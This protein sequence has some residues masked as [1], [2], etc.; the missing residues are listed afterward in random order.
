MTPTAYN[1][2]QRSAPL[3]WLFAKACP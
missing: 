3:L 1:D 2:N